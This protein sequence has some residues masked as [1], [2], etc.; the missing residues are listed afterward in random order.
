MLLEILIV[1]ILPHG[2]Q[3]PSAA[4]TGT[5]LDWPRDWYV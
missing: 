5:D 4:T 1:L 3:T 2:K